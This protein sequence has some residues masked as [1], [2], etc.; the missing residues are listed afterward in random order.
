MIDR[1]LPGHRFDVVRGDTY[2]GGRLL[3]AHLVDEGY[4]HIAFIGGHPSASSLTDRLGGYQDALRRAGLRE[5]IVL[6]HHDQTNGDA[7]IRTMVDRA[8]RGGE[9]VPEAIIAVNSMVA[10]GAL[11]A[12]RDLGLDVPGDVALAGFDDFE[13]ASQIDPFLTVV[14]QPAYEIGR[15]AMQLLLERF[16]DVEREPEERVLP[17]QLVVRRSTR[18]RVHG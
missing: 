7:I 11:L 8:R 12:L 14:K 9:P 6:G 17:V 5:R 13:I 1:R 15:E 16:E 10:L 3:T 4:R 18:R 2:E